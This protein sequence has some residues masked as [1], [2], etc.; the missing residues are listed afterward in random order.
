MLIWLKHLYVTCVFHPFYFKC[1]CYQRPQEEEYSLNVKKYLTSLQWTICMGSTLSASFSNAWVLSRCLVLQAEMIDAWQ[2]QYWF[3]EVCHA[4]YSIIWTLINDL[5]IP[6]L[7][8]YW[9]HVSLKLKCMVSSSCYFQGLWSLFQLQPMAK[10]LNALK[11]FSTLPKYASN[12]TSLSLIHSFVSF[13]SLL[14][15]LP[16]DSTIYSFWQDC[17]F[18]HSYHHQSI[19]C[20]LTYEESSVSRMSGNQPKTFVSS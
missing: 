10:L 15:Y 13:L 19:L 5:S 1:S 4:I 14:A 7:N 12:F 9:V 16:I 18:C 20:W 6:D 8:L 11:L 3:Q 17:C 2:L